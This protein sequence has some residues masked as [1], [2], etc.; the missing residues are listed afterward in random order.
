MFE[1]GSSNFQAT[2]RGVE[3]GAAGEAG[4][5]AL[6]GAGAGA[7]DRDGALRRQSGK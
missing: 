6:T 5:E 3:N 4:A 7:L 2:A 1:L